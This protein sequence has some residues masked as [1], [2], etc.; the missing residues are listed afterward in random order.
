MANTKTR[1]GEPT[2]SEWEHDRTA[3]AEDVV[4]GGAIGLVGGA[5]VGAIA[6]GPIGAV[7]GAVIGGAAS[8]AGVAAVDNLELD[9]DEPDVMRDSD[10]GFQAGT[11]LPRPDLAP[12]PTDVTSAGA[13]AVLPAKRRRS[14]SDSANALTENTQRVPKQNPGKPEALTSDD[15][16]TIVTP[17]SVMDDAP[18]VVSAPGNVYDT[19]PVARDAEPAIRL[20]AYY[21]YVSRGRADGA[22]LQDWLQ[23]E[24]EYWARAI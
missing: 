3:S 15:A 6:G 13:N 12:I 2:E 1:A 16:P 18:T 4:E 7:V 20:S 22:A 19:P 23:A 8:A 21:I 17:L 11:A 5:I 14:A 24:R 9:T 10:P